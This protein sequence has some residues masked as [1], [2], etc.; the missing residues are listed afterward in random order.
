[1]LI[2]DGA[3][4]RLNLSAEERASRRAS[5]ANHRHVV[6]EDAGHAV[7]RHQPARLAELILDHAR[8]S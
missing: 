6:I 2:V 3:E 8:A 5:F 4:S 1:V 7:Q